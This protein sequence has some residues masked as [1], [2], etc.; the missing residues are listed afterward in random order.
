MK[1]W[2][3]IE[4]FE[5]WTQCA[6]AKNAMEGSTVS[7]CA[8]GAIKKAYRS[9]NMSIPIVKMA[10]GITEDNDIPRNKWTQEVFKKIREDRHPE[11]QSTFEFR[12]EELITSTNDFSRFDSERAKRKT[13]E[14]LVKIMKCLDI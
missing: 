1:A 11:D 6:E 4:K 7:R 9:E 3:L 14:S 12:A 8:L 2:K 13:H 5:D 10:I